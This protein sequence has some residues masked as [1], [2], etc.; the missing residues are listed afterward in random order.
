MR[1]LKGAFSLLLAALFSVGCA[2]TPSYRAHPSIKDKAK[3]I[4][5]IA[6]LPPRIDVFKINAGGLGEKMDLWSEQA[7]KNLITAL[8]DRLNSESGLHLKIFH[9]DLFSKELKSNFDETYALFEVVTQSVLD[10]TYGTYAQRFDEK[11]TDFNYSLG[12]EVQELRM[13]SNDALLILIG[14]DHIS[15]EGQIA[16]QAGTVILAGLVGSIIIPK[17]GVTAMSGALIDAKTGSVLWYKFIKSD[18]GYDL[19]DSE[20]A[21]SFVDEFLKDFPLK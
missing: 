4:K 21:T 1:V 9:E 2:S 16:L 5:S 18:R 6:L 7:K 12:K 14:R 8:E 13:G 11:I 15:S 3:K 17:G 19:R 10:H 20:S